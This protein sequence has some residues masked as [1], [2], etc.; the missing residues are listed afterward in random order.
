MGEAD[1]DRQLLA[2]CRS[3]VTGADQS[4]ASC[5]TRGHADDHIVDK[6]A[7][8]AVHG[9]VRFGVTGACQG[10]DA[11]FL[12]DGDIAVYFLRKRAF[13]AF[14]DNQ[15]VV[16]DRYRHARGNRNRKFSDT[17]HNCTSNA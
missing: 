5:K 6:R 9:L 17:R 11:I 1:I 10:E 8:K 16:I 13:G 14:D 4:R 15:V 12:F 2:V 3:A 7:V